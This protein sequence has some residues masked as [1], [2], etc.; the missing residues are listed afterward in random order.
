[1]FYKDFSGVCLSVVNMTRA[2]VGSFIHFPY[3]CMIL[4]SESVANQFSCNYNVEFQNKN[5]SLSCRSFV[6]NITVGL[7]M[8]VQMLEDSIKQRKILFHENKEGPSKANCTGN[9]YKI[10]YAHCKHLWL[11]KVN[12]S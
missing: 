3:F 9:V 12:R 2:K 6:D 7:K 4:M 1:M 10:Q 5:Y 8:K 11:I